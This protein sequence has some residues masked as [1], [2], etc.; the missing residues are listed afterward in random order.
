MPKPSAGRKHGDQERQPGREDRYEWIRIEKILL[1]KS[2]ETLDEKTVAVIAESILVFDLLQPIGVRRVTEKRKDGEIMEKIALAFGAHRLEA[3]KRL[4]RKEIPCFY[5]EGDE[6]DAQLVRLG[7]NLWR[8]RTS[9][10]RDAERLVEYFKF[11]SAKLSGQPEKAS[12]GARR[13]VQ[14]WQL[15]SCR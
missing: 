10:L 15:V 6:T 11:A 2:D 7:E 14:H 13:G 4:G 8:K 5:V 12:S 1:P 3:M 9:V